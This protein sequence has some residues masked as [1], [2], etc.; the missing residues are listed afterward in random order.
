M[1]IGDICN[2]LDELARQR[3]V[4]WGEGVDLLFCIT[5]LSTFINNIVYMCLH[6]PEEI[7]MSAAKLRWFMLS[8]YTSFYIEKSNSMA[9]TGSYCASI[10]KTI[11]IWCQQSPLEVL[12]TVLSN[13]LISQRHAR[14]QVLVST[15]GIPA[16]PIKTK[17]Y[18]SQ[19]FL[20]N[21]Q[22]SNRY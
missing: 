18:I 21:E 8:V 19:V 17:T 12:I 20:Q 2:L 3:N 11:L 14:N 5:F 1:Y 16:K 9:T 10:R 6:H 15:A 7:N 4:N 13:E 22:S